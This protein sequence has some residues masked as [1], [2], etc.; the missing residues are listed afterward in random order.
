MYICKDCNKQ[1]NCIKNGVGCDFGGGHVYPGDVYECPVCHYE[2][3]NTT[4][5]SI[6][7]PNYD[8]LDEYIAVDG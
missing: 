4:S 5:N 6:H 1:M 8:I 3:V 7:D 2:I